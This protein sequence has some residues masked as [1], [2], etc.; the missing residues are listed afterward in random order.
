MKIFIIGALLIA[1]NSLAQVNKTVTIEPYK[2]L[3]YGAFFKSLTL[4]S[5]DT[6]AEFIDGFTF[7]WGYQ[8]E[9]EIKE[10]KLDEPLMDAGD[11]DYE[12]IRQVSR[13]KV[14]HDYEFSLSLENQVYL[15]LGENTNSL[16]E[17]S[18]GVYLYMDEIRIYV[19][20][21]LQEE[22]AEILSGTSKIG[23]FKFTHPGTITLLSFK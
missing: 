8:Y 3:T 13:T 19:P 2:S 11:T 23:V 18:E 15:G 5:E 20:D 14:D 17:E 6:H 9:L 21:D 16:V 7:E 10:T 12:L 22:F 1:Q 4:K